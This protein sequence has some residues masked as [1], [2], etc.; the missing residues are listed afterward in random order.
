MKCWTQKLKHEYSQTLIIHTSIIFTCFSGSI[1][2]VNITVV[3]FEICNNFFP[4]WK[5]KTV[6]MLFH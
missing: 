1:F 2:L 4:T 6:L 5:D 3:A